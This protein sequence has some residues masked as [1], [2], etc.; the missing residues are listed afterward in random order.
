MSK[1]I[2]DTV[3]GKEAFDTVVLIND[4]IDNDFWNE[5]SISEKEQKRLEDIYYLYKLEF[6][7]DGDSFCI[8]FLG[9]QLWNSENDEREYDDEKDDYAESIKTHIYRKMAE[10]IG[11]LKLITNYL[12]KKGE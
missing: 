2:A 4:K 1:Y 8:E 12:P 6:M 5:K 7:S 3:I 11:D 10:T 9:I